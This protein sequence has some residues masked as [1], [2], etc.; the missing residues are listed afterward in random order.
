MDID[1]DQEIKKLKFT[2]LFLFGIVLRSEQRI[3]ISQKIVPQIRTSIKN[4]PSFARWVFS[5]LSKKHSIYEF[6]VNCRSTEVC[7]IICSIFKDTLIKVYSEERSGVIKIVKKIRTSTPEDLPNYYIKI[8]NDP[9]QSISL[10]LQCL[11]QF[12]SVSITH[13]EIE[14]S[15]NLAQFYFNYVFNLYADLGAG[16]RFIL[17]TF[18]IGYQC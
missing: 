3:N 8:M 16:M 7:R 11:Y 18:K 9:E 2:F 4:S 5:C 17:V 15:H 14:E 1:G 6:F 13:M 10:S 12:I